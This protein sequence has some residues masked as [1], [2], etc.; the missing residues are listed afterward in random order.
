MGLG[1]SR[2]G[3]AR[4]AIY[5]VVVID[6][7][8]DFRIGFV[9]VVELYYETSVRFLTQTVP[10]NSDF[11]VLLPENVI[12]NVRLVSAVLVQSLVTVCK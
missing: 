4:N 10:T 8:L 12:P 5:V 9:G 6:T 7:E 11:D 2:S 1:Q 3:A